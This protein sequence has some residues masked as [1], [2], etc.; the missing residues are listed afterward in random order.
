MILKQVLIKV[1]SLKNPNYDLP[2]E[3]MCDASNNEVGAILG[4]R[5]IRSH[6][7]FLYKKLNNPSFYAF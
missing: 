1:S 2:F 7:N 5:V 4:Q 3:N 6:F